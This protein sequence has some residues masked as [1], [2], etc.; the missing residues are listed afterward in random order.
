LGERGKDVKGL[1]GRNSIPTHQLERKL[2]EGSGSEGLFLYI[3]KEPRE[4][5]TVRG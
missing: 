4:E 2:V 1:E 3:L 5:E